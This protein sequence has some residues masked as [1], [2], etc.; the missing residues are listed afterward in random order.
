[1]TSIPALFIWESPPPGLS[2]A[3]QSTRK[4]F[5]GRSMA[6]QWFLNSH[7]VKL[8]VSWKVGAW[9]ED[10]SILTNNPLRA[11]IEISWLAQRVKKR[12]II[13]ITGFIITLGISWYCL[14]IRFS[15]SKLGNVNNNLKGFKC[16]EFKWY[17]ERYFKNHAPISVGGRGQGGGLAYVGGGGLT[18]NINCLD[19]TYKLIPQKTW[20]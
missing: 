3:N 4:G 16:R 6:L 8:V 11:Q 12:R 5:D 20:L 14:N 7:F 1:M 17:I 15:K 2:V 13:F 19:N 18:V 10:R 9:Y